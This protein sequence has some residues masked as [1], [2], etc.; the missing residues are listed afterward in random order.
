M[1][2]TPRDIGI[3]LGVL[4]PSSVQSEQW[5]QWISD[6]LYLIG[7]HYRD[8]GGV[9]SLDPDDVDYVVRR[10][11]VDHARNPSSE[12]QVDVRIDDGQVSRRYAKAEG[13]VTIGD[14]LWAILEPSGSTATG[15]FT[16]GPV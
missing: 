2:V 8:L 15:A 14:D 11:V 12:T 6:A 10:A 16:I 7:R 3:E 4:S 5:S 9:G 1:T 13:K